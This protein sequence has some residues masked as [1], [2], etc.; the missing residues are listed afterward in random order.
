[1][2]EK[3]PFVSICLLTYNRAHDLPQSLDSLLAQSHGDFELIINDDRSPDNTEA[4]CRE[5]EQKDSR[6]KYF[7]NETNLR[8]ADNQNA[9]IQRAS[10]D[11]VA[12]VHD[13]DVYRKDLIEKWTRAL[14]NE[15]SVGMVFNQYRLVQP[16]GKETISKQDLPSVSSGQ[17]F[18]RFMLGRWHS[19]IFGIVMV[20]K[21]A[22]EAVGPFDNRFPTLADIDMWMRILARFDVVYVPEPLITIAPREKGHHNNAGNIKVRQQLE[23][24]CI[25]N[26]ARFYGPDTTEGNTCRKSLEKD[27]RRL[28]F[29]SIFWCLKRTKFKLACG[30]ILF[31]LTAG[32]RHQKFWGEGLE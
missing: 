11:Y 23:H 21:S 28:N 30:W 32:K 1:L 20:R 17:E 13:G 29:R 19:P 14:V 12:I 2:K 3:L 7:K 24:I 5:Y 8:Y 31:N 25:M 15:S 22:V 9:A 4:I 18:L 6:V 27:F 10:S 26:A 16:D